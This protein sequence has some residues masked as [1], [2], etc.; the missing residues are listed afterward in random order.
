V[1]L[2]PY[3]VIVYSVCAV[4]LL[5]VVLARGV[6]LAG[7]PPREW[8]IFA[9][10]AIGPGLLGHTLI[11]WTLAHLESSV[12]SVSL[13]GEPVGATVLAALVLAE[14]P[15]PYTV[16]GGVVVLAGIYVTTIARESQES[17]E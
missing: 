10:L 7:Y 2:I 8:L 1:A 11:N 5:V 15:T 14:T 6:P 12:V 9:G 17:P 4:G 3:V 16:V 13:L